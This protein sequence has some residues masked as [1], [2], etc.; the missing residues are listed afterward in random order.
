MLLIFNRK[1][2]DFFIR[3]LFTMCLCVCKC[4]FACLSSC[5][6][7]YIVLILYEVLCYLT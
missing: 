5:L 3:L 2:Y 7:V 1:K 4:V 6:F